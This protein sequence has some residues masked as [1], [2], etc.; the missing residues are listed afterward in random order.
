MHEFMYSDLQHYSMFALRVRSAFIAYN[1]CTFYV[2][3]E[4]RS[5]ITGQ[6]CRKQFQCVEAISSRS[7]GSHTVASFQFVNP[8]NIN[9]KSKLEDH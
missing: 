5:L 3:Q 1:L 6:R 2:Y 7:L 9:A 4:Q 8:F